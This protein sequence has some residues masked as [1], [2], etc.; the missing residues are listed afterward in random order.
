MRS[1][2]IFALAF[3]ALLSINSAAAQ[4]KTDSIKVWGNC[5]MCKTNIEKAAKS[6]GATTA[7]WDE[8]SKQ[9]KVSYTAKT[10]TTKIQQA[11]AK[12]GYDT[13]DFTA[14]DKAYKGLHTCCQYDRKATEPATEVKQ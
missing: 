7:K 2:K 12:A 4:T 14:N 9:L 5:G 6:A 10:S 13:Q 11:V 8:D 3:I 1:I